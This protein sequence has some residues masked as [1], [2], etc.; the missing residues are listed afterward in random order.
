MMLDATVGLGRLAGSLMVITHGV[1]SVLVDAVVCSGVPASRSGAGDWRLM[2]WTLR[3][4]VCSA[5]G[6][7]RLGTS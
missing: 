1:S 2:M 6:M 5:T 4:L 3:G 7:A